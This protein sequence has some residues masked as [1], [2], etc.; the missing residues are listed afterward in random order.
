MLS[1]RK[2]YFVFVLFR[3]LVLFVY[4]LKVDIYASSLEETK[5][6]PPGKMIPCASSTSHFQTDEQETHLKPS[7]SNEL[8]IKKF[9]ALFNE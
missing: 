3:C 7:L 6:G 2:F 5:L 4:F 8:E 9:K 1:R